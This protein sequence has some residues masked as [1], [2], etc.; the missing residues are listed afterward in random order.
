MS[1]VMI[2][3]MTP[4]E[5][6]RRLVQSYARPAEG[7]QLALLLELADF[8]EKSGL[9]GA[10]P[11]PALHRV[12]PTAKECWKGISEDARP[13]GTRSIDPQ[14]EAG[15][16]VLPWVGPMYR[17]GG[18]AVL[19][20]NLRYGGEHWEFAME[21][22]ITL[23]RNGGQEVSLQAGRRAH[24]S[25]WATGTMKDAA[26]VYRSATGVSPNGT[27]DGNELANALRRIARIQAI[28]CSPV[29]GRSSPTDNMVGHCPRQFLR[30]E[31]EVLRPAVVLA[32]GKATHAALLGLGDNRLETRTRAFQRGKLCVWDESIIVFLMTHPA[33]GRW[34][35]AHR[36][37]AESLEANP[38]RIP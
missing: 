36:E 35:L 28:K 13:T 6:N 9:M 37:L 4:E 14:S 20:L 7:Q 16:I 25:N 12:C 24:G 26:A 3:S 21:H 31:L 17:P 29:G 23:D 22:R 33:H 8:H 18:V 19:G 2:A 5:L 10:G 30:K 27:P 38:V 15:C 32:Y 1:G 11:L 34:N